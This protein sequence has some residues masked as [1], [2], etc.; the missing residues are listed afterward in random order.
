MKAATTTA[1]G[2][3]VYAQ[4][5]DPVLREDLLVRYLPL[6]K[7]IAS[8]LLGSLPRSIRLQDL[9]SSGVLGLLSC[10]DNY[11]PDLGIKFES[12]ASNRIRGAMMDGLRELD[13]VPRSV[14][15]KARQVE[16]A[17]E[18]LTYRL[19]R[20][21]NDEEAAREMSLSMEDYFKL[22]EEVNIT[23]L[24]SLDDTFWNSRGDKSCLS[25]LAADEQEKMPDERVEETE[26]RET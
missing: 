10:M 25:D 16:K 15:Q 1:V 23:T 6:V 20:L 9:V 17:F 21:P 12:Y 22:L 4:T 14:R 8:H 2:W 3:E 5:R 11:N 24:L 19:G 7:R 13:W 26:L 18:G